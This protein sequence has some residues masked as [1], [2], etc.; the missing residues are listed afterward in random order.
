[1]FSPKLKPVLLILS[2]VGLCVVWIPQIDNTPS[3]TAN[4]SE[5]ESH[6]SDLAL[7]MTQDVAGILTTVA[8][9][10]L[11]LT[12]VVEKLSKGRPEADYETAGWTALL[13]FTLTV[14]LIHYLAN[15]PTWL[16]G[17][18]ASPSLF[19]PLALERLRHPFP[20]RRNAG[21]PAYTPPDYQLDQEIIILERALESQVVQIFLK[22]YPRCRAFIYQDTTRDKRGGV[23]LANRERLHLPGAVYIDVTLVCPFG[24]K[25]GNFLLGQE[26][27]HSYLY[28]P[29][30]KGSH[31]A[32]LPIQRWEDWLEGMTEMNWFAKIKEV[33]HAE[34]EAIDLTELPFLLVKEHWRCKEIQ[35]QPDS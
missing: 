11:I 17:F 22:R 12:L 9:A 33:H 24:A 6:E 7:R 16:S 28:R 5:I 21:L 15:V 30:S 35:L 18:A 23:L 27:V 13:A 8:I 26:R 14:I 31:L 3:D 29:D 19:I 32:H 25:P 4:K 20:I 34:S 1:M 2:I 10:A